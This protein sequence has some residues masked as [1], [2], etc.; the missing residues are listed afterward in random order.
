M[1]KKSIE[2]CL[3]V[4]CDMCNK[5]ILNK[6][7]ITHFTVAQSLRHAIPSL[8]TSCYYDSIFNNKTRYFLYIFFLHVLCEPKTIFTLFF[9]FEFFF[10]SKVFCFL[11]FLSYVIMLKLDDFLKT[12]WHNLNFYVAFVRMVMKEISSNLR[13][14]II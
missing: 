4:V 11:Y 3:H 8:H 1:F 12:K 13:F 5:K 2:E 6:R 7:K 10:R 14:E 9:P